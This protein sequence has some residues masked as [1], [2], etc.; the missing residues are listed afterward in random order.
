MYLHLGQDTIISHEDIVGIF[1]LDTATVE[2]ASRT[3][4]ANA[5]KAEEVVTITEQLPKAFVVCAAPQQTKQTVYISQISTVT[6]QKRT[7]EFQ[8]EQANNE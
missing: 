4:L 8:Y 7:N 5:Q 6:L 3:F 2:K 1:D